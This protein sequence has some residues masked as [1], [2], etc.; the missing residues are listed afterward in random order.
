[1]VM[2]VRLSSMLLLD[3]PMRHVHMLDFGVVVVV[4]VSGEQMRPVLATV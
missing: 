4:A 2:D 3:V 1:M